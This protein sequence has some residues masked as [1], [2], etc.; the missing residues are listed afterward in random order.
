VSVPHS[1]DEV[2]M[3][4]PR[5]IRTRSVNRVR[6]NG[7][8]NTPYTLNSNSSNS[9]V[10]G[11]RSKN[12]LIQSSQSVPVISVCGVSVPKPFSISL[13]STDNTA[14]NNLGR[15]RPRQS[16]ILEVG[17]GAMSSAAL[18]PSN[19]TRLSISYTLLNNTNS[20][21]ELSTT[22]RA[23]RVSSTAG[24]NSSM[25][26]KPNLAKLSE[27]KIDMMMNSLNEFTTMTR[28]GESKKN[29]ATSSITNNSNNNNHVRRPSF[30]A[31]CFI[32]RSASVPCLCYRNSFSVSS[33]AL[34]ASSS[35]P[36]E[37]A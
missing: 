27:S 20:G 30:V 32:C 29:T 28:M 12:S 14:T 34:G 6:F 11:S 19:P 25:I 16:S 9:T 15:A 24:V 17:T 3:P 26:R 7:T 36:S 5:L 2:K 8:F 22:S 31:S 1:F 18:S 21:S 23:N 4:E 37:E 35:A 33:A 10:D 13:H